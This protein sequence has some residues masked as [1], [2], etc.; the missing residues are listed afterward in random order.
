MANEVAVKTKSEV[1]QTLTNNL[2]ASLVAVKDAL[3]GDFNRSRFLQN[4][5]SVVKANPNL[6][7]YNQTEVLTECLKASYLGL[8]FMNKEAW[9]VPYGSHV[10]FQ[11]GYK[12]ACKFVKKYSIRPIQDIYAK[13]VRKGDE[14]EYGDTDGKQYLTWKPLPFNGS[15]IIGCFACIQFKDGGVLYEVMSK[16]DVDKIRRRSKASG[17]GPWVTD[18]EQMMLKTVMKRITKNVEV[19]FDNIEQHNAWD[20]DNAEF[21]K[22]I[23]ASEVVDPFANS[24]NDN[25]IDAEAT[26]IDMPDVPNFA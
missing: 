23:P 16:E 4:T 13:A 6:L 21:S 2:D 8:D 26:V 14:F 7:Q 20:S 19:D 1:I 5:I 25:V 18:Y 12:G 11:L 3:P 17:S 22:D 10:Q 9:L 15:D 24:N